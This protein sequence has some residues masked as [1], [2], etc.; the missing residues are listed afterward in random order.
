MGAPAEST[1]LSGLDRDIGGSGLRHDGVE[2]IVDDNEKA[3]PKM[4]E[5][6]EGLPVAAAPSGDSTG[7]PAFGAALLT[8]ATVGSGLLNYAYSLALAYQLRPSEYAQFA[9]A[10]ALVLLVGLVGSVGVPYVVAQEIRQ[11]DLSGDRR[12]AQTAVN[13]AFWV[14]VATGVVAGTIMGLLTLRLS[15]FASAAVVAAT[16]FVLAVGSTSLGILQGRGRT[17]IVGG[18][19]F[20]EVVVKF[21]LG[22][23]LV[24]LVHR[25]A[26]LALSGLLLGSLVLLGSL[27][28]CWREVGR[29]VHFGAM[30]TLLVS[31]LHIG[32]VQLGVGIVATIDVYVVAT[33]KDYNSAAAFQVAST[34][35]KVTL[36]VSSAVSFAT[37]PLLNSSDG[38]RLRVKALQSYLLISGAVALVLVSV[39]ERLL[40]A[41]LPDSYGEVGRWL[42]YTAFM[43]VGLGLANLFTTFVQSH[44]S[45]RS[46]QA[47]RQAALIFPLL[48]VS[49]VAMSVSAKVAGVHG[50]AIAALGSAWLVALAYGSMRN[51]RAAV[52]ELIRGLRHAVVTLAILAVL[53]AGLFPAAH[54]PTLWLVDAAVLGVLATAFAFPEVVPRRASARVGRP[55]ARSTSAQ[56]ATPPQGAP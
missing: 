32:A 35:G 25:S 20:A 28:I 42:P 3:K 53:A 16:L 1:A 7:K 2:T 11:A 36:F 9:A 55:E 19:L 21:V 43:G 24:V 38:L 22:V 46:R 52:V 5:P 39:P 54:V 41:V 45:V 10:Q 8:L 40:R 17:G 44:Q 26:T 23:S 49:L 29:P 34:L 14:N 4:T 31:S 27:G 37:Y 51:E 48:G 6:V 33:T 30:K 15:S 12:R 13:F 50:V 18:I 56:P 47:T